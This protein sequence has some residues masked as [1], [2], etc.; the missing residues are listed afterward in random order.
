M[1]HNTQNGALIALALSA[2]L[3]LAGCGGGGGSSSGSASTMPTPMPTP[4]PD[5]SGG[6]T[7]TPPISDSGGSASTMPDTITMMPP[8]TTTDANKDDDF[9]APP[10]PPPSTQQNTPAEVAT[11]VTTT[12]T[13]ATTVPDSLIPNA[14]TG[15]KEPYFMP[16]G[17]YGGD[18]R[19]DDES[20]YNDGITAFGKRIEGSFVGDASVRVP[21]PP[22]DVRT[23]WY[24]GWTGAGVNLLIVDGFGR[25]GSRLGSTHGYT[26]GMSALEIA[27]G[28]TYYAFESGNNPFDTYSRGGL[29]GADNVAVPASTKID[30]INMS[31]GSDPLVPPITEDAI[32]TRV[33]KLSTEPI[34]N[35]V[36]GGA[37]LTNADDAVITKAAGNENA[38]SALALEN[39]AMATYDGT[40]HRVLIVGA[41][42]RY[43][44]EGNARLSGYS[45]YAGIVVPVQERFL[46]EYGGSPYGD[47]AY[48]CDA[49]TPANIGCRNLQF[50]GDVTA[51]GTSYAAPRVAGFAAL[52]RGKF[53]GLGGAQTAKILLDTATYQGL[54]CYPRCNVAIYGQGRVDI[55]D[56][57]SPIGKLE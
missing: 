55:L 23:A 46:V 9:D 51:E 34:W 4:T 10:P 11:A 5:T 16:G 39:W 49:S 2:L 22:W 40:R 29:R 21:N 7:M 48:L 41:L 43:A 35:D 6:T 54:V 33:A 15:T 20:F 8:D 12:S 38:D 26:V 57:L 13:P 53:P 30:V 47:E 24:Q 14:G 36:F 17:G 25:P 32:R 44:Q 27:P 42:N 45:N 19:D 56:A 3:V 37:F 18:I 52:V 50:L 28:A 31:L 1:K